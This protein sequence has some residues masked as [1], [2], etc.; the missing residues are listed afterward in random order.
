VSGPR[1]VGPAASVAAASAGPNAAEAARLRRACQ[2]LEG[3]FLRHLFQSMRESV[4]SDEGMMGSS[5]GQEIFTSMLDDAM[6]D[7]ASRQL[8]R[9]VADALFQ[10]LGRRL[11]AGPAP[12]TPAGRP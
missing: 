11:A 7:K 2:D 5:S 10:Q 1:P 12:T 3:V 9:G 8:S 4:P 6:A